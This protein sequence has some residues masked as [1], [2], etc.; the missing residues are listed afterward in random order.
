MFGSLQQ[1][2]PLQMLGRIH[3]L[4]DEADVVIHY[5]GKS[6]DIKH[7]NKE[8]L[9]HK[10]S[11]PSPFKQ[12]D[13]LQTMRQNFK[14]PSNKL[15]YILEELELGE[16][17]DPG[18][19]KTWDACLH[20]GKKAWE[21]MKTYNIGDVV[22]LEKLYVELRPWIKGHPNRATYDGNK[23]QCPVCGSDHIHSKGMGGGMTYSYRRYKCMGCQTPLRG[24]KSESGRQTK[25]VVA[26]R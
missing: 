5:N 1:R 13:L 14:F 22:E 7:L 8:F 24:T 26:T 25:Y 11:P 2:K 17:G 20:G 23:E 18:G 4:L 19:M 15:G 6:F 9:K 3:K 12:V 10:F 16:K 21:T